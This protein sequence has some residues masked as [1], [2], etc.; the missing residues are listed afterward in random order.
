MKDKIFKFIGE[1]VY[2]LL[3]GILLLAVIV[4][5]STIIVEH[6]K[7]E[8][9]LEAVESF[10]MLYDTKVQELHEELGI[11]DQ[12]QEWGYEFYNISDEPDESREVPDLMTEATVVCIDKLMEAQQIIGPKEMAEIIQ[13]VDIQIASARIVVEQYINYIDENADE[14]SVPFLERIVFECHLEN[15]RD[16]YMVDH[17]EALICIQHNVKELNKLLDRELEKKKR[18]QGI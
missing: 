12:D 18:E 7:E 15:T 5:V 3:K 16:D 2:I 11:V 17:T 10:E 9:W 1:T 13:C 4:I 14:P 8:I 6:E